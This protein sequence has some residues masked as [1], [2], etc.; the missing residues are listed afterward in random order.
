MN[1]RITGWKWI[2]V[3]ILV[4]GILLRW[5]HIDQRGIILALGFL[6][7]GVISFIDALQNKYHQRITI[8]TLQVVLPIIVIIA[9]IGNIFSGNAYY[10]PTLVIILIL[11]A[12][13]QRKQFQRG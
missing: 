4:A 13:R 3:A 5:M 2:A 9:A 6:S 1:D 7:F 10:V 11:G 8:D 12:I